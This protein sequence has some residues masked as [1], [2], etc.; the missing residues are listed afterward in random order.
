LPNGKKKKH[1]IGMGT[2]GT[3][4]DDHCILDHLN[5]EKINLSVQNLVYEIFFQVTESVQCFLEN[6]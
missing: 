5:P 4:K 6:V 1:P 3:K 2:R